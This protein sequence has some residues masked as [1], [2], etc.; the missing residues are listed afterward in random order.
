M[1]VVNN[2]NMTRD[3]LIF[4]P[5]PQEI[6]QLTVGV[7]LQCSTIIYPNNNKITTK[8]IVTRKKFYL[9]ANLMSSFDTYNAKTKG[10]KYEI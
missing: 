6:L 10:G 7:V 2:S 9:K 4:T 1:C 8:K 5:S 3:V